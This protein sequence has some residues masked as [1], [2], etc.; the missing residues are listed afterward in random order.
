MKEKIKGYD[1]HY[2]YLD[3]LGSPEPAFQMVKYLEH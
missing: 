1:I 2:I 3:F